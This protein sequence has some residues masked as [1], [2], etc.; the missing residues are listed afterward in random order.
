MLD[1]P[2]ASGAKL[3]N[4]TIGGRTLW[5]SARAGGLTEIEEFLISQGVRPGLADGFWAFLL[6]LKSPKRQP[7]HTT[8]GQ[9]SA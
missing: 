3:P 9:S 4:R 2:V 1:F 7:T 5:V 8:D 6:K